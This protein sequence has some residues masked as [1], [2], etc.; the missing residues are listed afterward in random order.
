MSKG[1]TK[2]GSRQERVAA[3][4]ARVEL[5]LALLAVLE[6]TQSAFFGL[7]VDAGKQ[8]LGALMEADRTALCGPSG[9]HDAERTHGRAGAARSAVVLGGRTI[10]IERPR[11]RSRAGEEARLPSF[12]AAA[13]RDP[14]DRHTL[15][16][17]AAGVSMRRYER[18]L[19]PVPRSV[20]ERAT[21]KSAVS[22]R[23]V[24]LTETKLAAW[25]SAP[26]CELDLRV[27]MI[28]GIA[29]R[30]HCVLVALGID[31]DGTK[32]ALGLREGTTENAGV[33]KA[34]LAELI[35]RGLPSDRAL[36]F[37]IDGAKALRKA[38]AETFG[39]AALV[40]RCQLHKQRNVLEHL[41]ERLRPSVAKALA[42]AWNSADAK[43]ARRQLERLAAS[44]ETQHPGAAASIREGLDETLT[45][46]EL[47]ITGALYR[48]LRSTN[49]IENL[50]GAIGAYTHHV[51][52]WRGGRMILRWVGAAMAEAATHFRRIRGHDDLPKL[53]AALRRHEQCIGLQNQA[54]VA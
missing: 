35:E 43:L 24:A 14:L 17:L 29:F 49:P 41:P 20:Q 32:H 21:S 25:F 54:E 34:L 26:L 22:R 36:L 27:V 6:D 15:E 3:H 11:V 46:Q 23:F 1:L 13:R 52:R 19:D 47:G 42:Q 44:L 40:H 39:R 50:N 37:V 33:A 51:K 7:C 38:I 28:D 4:T 2:S 10:A 18:S 48:T 53:V 12:T 45:L 30:K 8:V 5:P 9:Q 16:A 31:G